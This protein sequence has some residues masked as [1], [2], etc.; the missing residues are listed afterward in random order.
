[1]VLFVIVFLGS[2]MMRNF[3]VVNSGS[4]VALG[5]AAVW[6]CAVLAWN[7]SLVR[8]SARRRQRLESY[9]SRLEARS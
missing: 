3:A 7:L 1:V 9:A 5:V 2:H 8:R 4:F 6:V